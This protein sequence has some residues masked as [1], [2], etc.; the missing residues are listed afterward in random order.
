MG[1]K[2]VEKRQEHEPAAF[3]HRQHFVQQGTGEDDRTARR[4][5]VKV[6]AVFQEPE[7]TAFVFF[8][9]QVDGNR[10]TPILE[11][12]VEIVPVGLEESVVGVFVA[13]NSEFLKV[14]FS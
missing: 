12:F 3:R 2:F 5:A 6:M 11:R 13:P 8:G 9:V 10:I 14:Q 7:I 4:R 1:L